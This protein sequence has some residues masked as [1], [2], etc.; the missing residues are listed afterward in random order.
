MQKPVIINTWTAPTAFSANSGPLAA[1]ESTRP[2]FEARMRSMKPD[3]RTAFDA[4]SAEAKIDSPA[5]FLASAI[6]S[7]NLMAPELD[8]RQK[9]YVT[10]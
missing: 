5:F 9:I 3:S 1:M 2:F 4:F 6:L 8:I 10:D 7:N